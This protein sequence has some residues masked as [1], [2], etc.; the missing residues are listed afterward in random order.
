V[1]RY[2]TE[3]ADV[4][5]A[6]GVVV[7]VDDVN[8]GWES[9]ARSSG[10]FA[11]APLGVVWH[12]TASSATPYSDLSYMCHGSA[13]APIGN[14]LLD[15]NGVV[16]PIAAGAA[17]TQGK[18]GPVTLSRG[19]VPVDAGNSQL[20]AIEAANSGTG[21]A[22]PAQQVDAYFATSNAL[23]ALFG[24]TPT[25]VI[26]HAVN[27]PPVCWTDRK[28]DPATSA[29]V[30]G[31]WVPA[32]V[33]SSGTW[34][35]GDIRAECAHRAGNPPPPTPGGLMFTILDIDGTDV[36]F[37]GNMDAHGIAAQI[38]WLNPERYAACA[39]LGAPVVTAAATDLANCDLLGPVPPGFNAA[40]FANVIT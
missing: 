5:T 23:N 26:T 22:W 6:A 21:E 25:D 17:N 38:T 32:P 13:D 3:L 4:L 7:A 39:R 40:Q 18:G 30:R 31:P 16:W 28:I 10:G 20:F 2:Y 34:A 8:A 27:D 1:G 19:T 11:A 9:R 35:I 14:V 24:N 12:H 36:A 29:G 15:R 37:G 33:S